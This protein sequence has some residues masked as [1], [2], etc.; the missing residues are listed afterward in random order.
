MEF[1]SNRSHELLYPSNLDRLDSN[2]KDF[3]KAF[4]MAMNVTV[5]VEAGAGPVT[6]LPLLQACRAIRPAFSGTRHQDAHEFLA[7]LIDQ[8]HHVVGA[9]RLDR[10]QDPAKNKSSKKQQQQQ[11]QPQVNAITELFFGEQLIQLTC[12]SCSYHTEKTESFFD[13]MLPIVQEPVKKKKDGFFE[14]LFAA[15]TATATATPASSSISRLSDCVTEWTREQCVQLRCERCLR[16]S[17]TQFT[18]RISVS[19]FPRFMTV[20]LQRFLYQQDRKVNT[21]VK[22]PRVIDMRDLASTSGCASSATGSG[23]SGC[24]GRPQRS[25][26]SVLYQHVAQC[27]HFGAS[28]H[29]GHYTAAVSIKNRNG[30]GKDK[31]KDSSGSGSGSS[32][33]ANAN[34]NVD[35]FTCDDQRVSPMQNAP[36]KSSWLFPNKITETKK[37][38]CAGVP[39]KLSGASPYIML[40]ERV[41]RVKT[42]P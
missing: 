33:N 16:D 11:Q 4:C 28:P 38:T 41:E 34:A 17:K 1:W 35:Y 14:R 22:I 13:I 10:R 25:G 8:L 23:R 5:G 2:A 31:D 6:I 30:N 18:K 40:Y 27:D 42:S 9:L 39:L 15:A 21:Q 19:R 32:V 36:Q 24:S 3:L 12:R 29:V 37:Q 26:R 7:L 20:L